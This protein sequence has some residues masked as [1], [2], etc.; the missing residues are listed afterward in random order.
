MNLALFKTLFQFCE[1]LEFLNLLL[2]DLVK[3]L[4]LL[5]LVVGVAGSFQ[6]LHSGFAREV[7][8]RIKVQEGQFQCCSHDETITEEVTLVDPKR[9]HC[10]SVRLPQNV[11]VRHIGIFW[12]KL[13]IQFSK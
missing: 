1:L 13:I 8:V 3:S 12:L 6:T 9:R 7:I 2:L 10:H 4:L 11:E 5:H